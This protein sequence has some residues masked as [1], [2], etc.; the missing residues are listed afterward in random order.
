G[1]LSC[2]LDSERP[3]SS[4]RNDRSRLVDCIDCRIRAPLHVNFDERPVRGAWNEK[5]GVENASLQSKTVGAEPRGLR[6]HPLLSMAS[7]TAKDNHSEARA[8][9]ARLRARP[10]LSDQRRAL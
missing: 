8:P 6:A 9:A 4:K 3:A 10:S 1:P 5:G 2:A 7:V